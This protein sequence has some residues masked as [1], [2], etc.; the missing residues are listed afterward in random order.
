MLSF[1]YLLDTGENGGSSAALA[2]TPL[3][4]TPSTRTD[5]PHTPIPTVI[6][7]L[8]PDAHIELFTD[9]TALLRRLALNTDYALTRSDCGLNRAEQEICYPVAILINTTATAGASLC[10]MLRSR[11][12][13]LSPIV[14]CVDFQ[15]PQRTLRA[16]VIP[17]LARIAPVLRDRISR[18]KAWVGLYDAE[19]GTSFNSMSQLARNPYSLAQGCINLDYLACTLQF[20]PLMA[21]LG[22]LKEKSHYVRLYS[23]W[24]F[25]AYSLSL[26]EL[27][28]VS[29]LILEGP[30]IECVGEACAK[31]GCAKQTCANRACA[32][33][34]ALSNRLAAFLFFIRDNYRQGNPFH[35]FRHAVDVLQATNFFLSRLD[36]SPDEPWTGIFTKY[37]KL[38]LLLASL[39]HDLGHPAV[40][41]QALVRTGAPI[42]SIFHNVSVLENFHQSQFRRACRSLLRCSAEPLIPPPVFAQ[43]DSLIES[44]ILATDMANHSVYVERMDGLLT[45]GAKP[46]LPLLASLLIKSAD[47]S[48]VCRPLRTSVKWAL[49]LGQEFKQV[50]RFE[51]VVEGRSQDYTIEPPPFD[52]KLMT[53]SK[54]IEAVPNM[55]ALQTMFIDRFADEFFRKIGRLIPPL[56]FLYEQL[57]RNVE[58]WEGSKKPETDESSG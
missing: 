7:H 45:S 47:I 43:M 56:G 12:R 41:N 44:S 35:N 4:G 16:G 29:Y 54:A 40:T 53:V 31:E 10:Q 39:G 17:A 27:L 11:F 30:F 57:G 15:N 55:S 48:N 20:V 49:S 26:D 25:D 1:V 3:A 36:I 23:T 14:A 38:A 52:V 2:S 42:A 19:L 33:S 28:Y 18:M 51:D 58:F 13:S 5:S 21:T 37:T 34:S 46:T 6:S 32:T 22:P 50:G 8:L 24:D 9:T